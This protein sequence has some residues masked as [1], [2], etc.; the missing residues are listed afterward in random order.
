[1]AAVLPDGWVSP[2]VAYGGLSLDEERRLRYEGSLFIDVLVG[3][4]KLED[5]S[6]PN[7]LQCGAHYF[8]QLFFCHRSFRQERWEVVGLSCVLLIAKVFD[9]TR[10][11]DPILT[12]FLQR[13][14][15]LVKAIVPEA[16]RYAPANVPNAVHPSGAPLV[17]PGFKPPKCLKSAMA[18][19]AEGVVTRE[20]REIYSS[21][22]CIVRRIF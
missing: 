13:F 11:L 19:T 20:C 7:K 12:V 1:M 21:K 3:H 18:M 6:G 17:P 16:M 9:Q 10:Q 15:N 14:P 2:S 4:L 5:R 8:F 22:K